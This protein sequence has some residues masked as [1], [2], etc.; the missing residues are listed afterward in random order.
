MA[1]WMCLA[2]IRCV[3][4]LPASPPTPCVGKWLTMPYCCWQAFAMDPVAL[5]AYLKTLLSST[6][7]FYLDLPSSPSFPRR[8]RSSSSSSTSSGNLLT[9]L[10]PSASS[11][12]VFSKKSDFDAL[13]KLLNDSKRTRAL[14]PFVEKLRLVK[15][16]HELGVMRKAGA[17]GSKG[18]REVMR[19]AEAGR[20]EGQVQVSSSCGRREGR[21]GWK[22]M[23]WRR[24]WQRAIEHGVQGVI[25]VTRERAVGGRFFCRWQ[26]GGPERGG[27]WEG[28]GGW[29]GAESSI[30]APFEPSSILAPFEASRTST[31]LSPSLARQHSSTSPLSTAPNDRRMFPS[32]PPDS[33]L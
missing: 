10:T 16:R 8:S 9:Y 22:T 29:T 31:D 21:W 15:S 3:C 12:D 11:L 17:I 27:V 33:T 23:C 20:S 1:R 25:G 4:A 6:S 14:A 28:Q 30:T 5:Q 2:P 32:S 13:V 18:M 24:R 7:H 19:F 26:T